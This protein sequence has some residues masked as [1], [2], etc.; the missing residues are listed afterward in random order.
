VDRAADRLCD[1]DV[2]GLRSVSDSFCEFSNPVSDA[3]IGRV[4][5]E[6]F[7]GLDARAFMM[8]WRGIE[9]MDPAFLLWLKRFFEVRKD[10]RGELGKEGGRVSFP[11]ASAAV[12]STGSG[13]GVTASVSTA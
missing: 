11:G 13:L 6:E 5:L 3:A 8:V 9:S 10:R 12:S 1:D 4:G 2:L 7:G